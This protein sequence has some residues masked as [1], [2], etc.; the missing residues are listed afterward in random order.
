MRHKLFKILAFF[1][2]AYS[3]AQNISVSGVVQDN[4]GMPIPGANI[5]I[6]GTMTGTTSDFDGNFTL[7]EVGIGDTISIS[8]VGYI[9]KDIVIT[10]S[11][12]LTIQ[13]DEDISQLEEVVVVGYGTQNKKDVTGAVSTVSAETLEALKPIDAAQALQGT[14]AGVSVT[15]PS[16]SP[17][18]TLI[19]LLEG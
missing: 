15:A 7:K 18:V 19:S 8:Y 14:S 12:A 11:A 1:F 17:V 4:T 9:T 16:G 6:E 5:I 3:S 13:L 10:S 2:I